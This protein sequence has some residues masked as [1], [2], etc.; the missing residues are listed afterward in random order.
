[1]CEDSTIPQNNILKLT[2][3][4]LET[5]DWMRDEVYRECL[6]R[7]FTAIVKNEAPEIEL[8]YVHGSHGKL[9]AIIVVEEENILTA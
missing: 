5:I 4:E 7:M 8:V 9:I 6:R 1:M 2:L 3:G